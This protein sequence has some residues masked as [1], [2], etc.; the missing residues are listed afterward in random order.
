MF[1]LKDHKS[2]EVERALFESPNEPLAAL[3]MNNNNQSELDAAFDG[4]P[5]YPADMLRSEA[6]QLPDAID[7]KQ[8]EVYLTHDDFVSIFQMK[9]MEFETLPN[10]RKQELKKR[11]KLF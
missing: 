8:K 11:H 1:F 4:Y 2:F 5:K 3:S 6:S 9:F 7:P 10:W